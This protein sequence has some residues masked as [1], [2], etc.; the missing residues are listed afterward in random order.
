[1]SLFI[2][3]VIY[4]VFKDLHEYSKVCHSTH[5]LCLTRITSD[6]N[7]RVIIFKHKYHC[8]DMQY[9]KWDF[10]MMWL[11]LSNPS[12]VTIYQILQLPKTPAAYKIF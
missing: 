3:I 1:M 10:V 5:D 7:I 12:F 6:S 4:F 2:I 8:Q 11:L 9:V